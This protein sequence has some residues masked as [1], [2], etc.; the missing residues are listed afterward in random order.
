MNPDRFRA[1]KIE[2][3]RD[4]NGLLEYHACFGCVVYRSRTPFHCDPCN[5]NPDKDRLKK[6]GLL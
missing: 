6:A 4:A 5:V 1:E 2:I 3:I